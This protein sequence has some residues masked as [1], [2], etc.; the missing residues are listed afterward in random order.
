MRIVILQGHP[1]PD[2]A[3]F[4]RVLAGDH[5]TGEKEAGH[6]VRMS[7]IA[8]VDF[9]LLAS[10]NDCEDG[11]PPPAIAKAQQTIARGVHLALLSSRHG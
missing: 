1:D 11:V 7:D 10:K 6:E 8:R 5:A 2:G 9:P 4:L 3:R